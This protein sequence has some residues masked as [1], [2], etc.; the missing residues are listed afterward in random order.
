MAENVGAQVAATGEIANGEHEQGMA[1][2]LL[3]FVAH[4]A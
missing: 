4:A 2:A 1:A 3:F